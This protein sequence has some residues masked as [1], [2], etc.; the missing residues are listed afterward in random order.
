MGML[1]VMALVAAFALVIALFVHALRADQS[2]GEHRWLVIVPLLI[3]AGWV[4]EVL[5]MG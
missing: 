5:I 1:I 4:L 3:V 2:P